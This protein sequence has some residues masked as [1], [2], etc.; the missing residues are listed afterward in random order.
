MFSWDRQFWKGTVGFV[1]S[2][3]MN[4]F[5]RWPHTIVMLVILLGLSPTSEALRKRDTWT[6]T[7]K[8]Q[9][10]AQAGGWFI[11]LGVTGA[12]AKITL[13]APKILEVAYVFED[14]PA[15]GKLLA[16]DKITGING[17][18]FTTA[19]KFGYGADFFG[20]QGPMMEFGE[21]LEAS[22][23]KLGGKLTLD[24]MRNEKPTKV[25]ISLGN[26]YGAFSKTYPYNCKKTDIIL[27]ES[28]EYLIKRQKPDGSWHG[29]PHI[30]AFAAL[31]MLGSPDK[32]HQASAK[33]AAEFCAKATTGKISYGGLDGWK[34][35]LFGT[36]LA[37]YYLITKEK[38]VLKEL[39]EINQWLHKAQMK[40]GG[41]GHRPADRPGGNGYGAI[42]VITM[43]AKMAWGLMIRCGL[44]VDATK[45]K[46]THDFVARGTN[47]I[48]YV[49]YKDRGKENPKYADMGRTGASAVAHY[50]SPVGGKTYSD[51]AKLNASCIGNHPVTFTDTH[52]SPLLGMAW[53]GLGALPDPAMLRKLMDHNR[54]HFA[55]AHC[56][57]GTFYYQPN[58]D[59][60]PQD[61]GAA[62]RLSATAT[63][64][65]ILSAKYKRLQMTG[66]K[67][68][69]Q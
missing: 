4:I 48:G 69:R 13:E 62:P 29:R 53:T 22:Q 2:T 57:D 46:A 17:V 16:G 37:E 15:H 32:K 27:K 25:S 65:L 7:T 58:R 33:L 18:P 43:Q 35:T 44:K 40:N 8:V 14:T 1:R 59:N 12:R 68:I 5:T 55:L 56:P 64:A 28:Y 61:F 36:Y 54:W 10:D 3:T 63:N 39:E 11:N 51:F 47:A 66:A 41:W 38:W 30:H 26:K 9:P 42:N 21:A 24:V 60:N 23:V 67:L 50:L 34:Y 19:H 31:A 6:K 20:Y 45:F 52:G 49:W